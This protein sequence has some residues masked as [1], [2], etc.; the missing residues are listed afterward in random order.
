[1][2]DNLFGPGVGKTIAKGLKTNRT[3]RCLNLKGNN[4]GNNGIAAVLK[5]L[6]KNQHLQ[7]LNLSANALSAS[8]GVLSKFVGKNTS[9]EVL[10]LGSN[11][12]GP[13]FGEQLA[14]ALAKNRTVKTLGK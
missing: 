9:L 5:S 14:A 1:M 3:L 4:L 13:V 10:I 11:V 6:A 7:H 2:Q 12:L 8:D